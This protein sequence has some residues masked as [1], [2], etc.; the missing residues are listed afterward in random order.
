MTNQTNNT[1]G[2]REQLIYKDLSYKLVGFAYEVG[3][4]L[5]EG[6]KEEVYRNAYALLL[7]KEG[8]VYKKEHYYPILIRGDV[9]AKRFFDFLIDDKIIIELKVGGKSYFNAYKQLLEYLKTSKY[10]LGLII[11]FTSDGVKAKRIPNIY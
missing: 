4:K 2:R 10:K 3:N 9:V 11:R 8:I 1:K 5:G 6:L 7:D